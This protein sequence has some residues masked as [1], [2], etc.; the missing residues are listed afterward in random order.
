MFALRDVC[1]KRYLS[2]SFRRIAAAFVG[3]KKYSEKLFYFHRFF[4]WIINYT[5][6]CKDFLHIG[7][8]NVKERML[9]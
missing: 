5:K 8:G 2:G 4:V 9:G 7:I 3:K 1:G 6:K